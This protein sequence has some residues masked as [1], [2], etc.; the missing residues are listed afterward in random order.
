M[1]GKWLELL[2]EIDT[3][4]K[5]T[6]PSSEAPAIGSVDGDYLQGLAKA[7]PGLVRQ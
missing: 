7:V 3:V 1:G 6:S 2:R 4:L 5:R